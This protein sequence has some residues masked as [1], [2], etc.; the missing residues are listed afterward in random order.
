M[1]FLDNCFLSRTGQSSAQAGT[2]P[3]WGAESTGGPPG[4]QSFYESQQSYNQPSYYDPN[5][6]RQ[7]TGTGRT[8][9]PGYDLTGLQNPGP[10]PGTLVF[11][12]YVMRDRF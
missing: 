4:S 5:P 6:Q 8:Q 9:T 7:G 11:L 3:S 1:P 12:F 10:G 2:E